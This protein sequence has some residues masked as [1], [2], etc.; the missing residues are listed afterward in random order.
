MLAAAAKLGVLARFLTVLATVLSIG[1]ALGNHA[2]AAGMCAF[3]CVSHV[4]VTSGSLYAPCM[5][6]TSSGASR[7]RGEGRLACAAAG[8][9]DLKKA[10]QTLGD[11]KGLTAFSRRCVRDR[12]VRDVAPDAGEPTKSLTQGQQ[13]Q[14]TGS[15]FR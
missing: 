7:P 9:G 8:L 10:R 15:S 4:R 14:T 12:R 13:P 2:L 6:I 5:R 1:T 11:Y 3:V